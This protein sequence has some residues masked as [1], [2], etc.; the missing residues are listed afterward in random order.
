MHFLNRETV[1]NYEKYERDI[2][3]RK[4]LA[5]FFVKK[6][7]F[8]ILVKPFNHTRRTL[9]SVKRAIDKSKLH[10]GSWPVPTLTD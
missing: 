3:G 5:F 1:V 10:G 2:L 8:E 9:S 7:L 6:I 4:G